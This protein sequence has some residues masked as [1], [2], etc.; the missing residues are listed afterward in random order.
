MLN[1]YQAALWYP[2]ARH[3]QTIPQPTLVLWA[4]DDPALGKSLTY[5][6]EE[7]VPNLRLHYFQN[8]GQWLHN[9]AAGEVND[10]LLAFLDESS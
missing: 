8:R 9:E 10:R 4:E 2:P 3:T 1:W 5:R 6:L 7:W